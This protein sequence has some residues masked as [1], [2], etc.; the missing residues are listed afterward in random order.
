MRVDPKTDS[1]SGRPEPGW[2]T[3]AAVGQRRW[4]AST[5]TPMISMGFIILA[6]KDGGK[7]F[8]ERFAETEKAIF[9]IA[10]W[11]KATGH[12]EPF[13]TSD[14][15]TLEKIM[16]RGAVQAELVE[17]EYQGKKKIVVGRWRPFS[18]TEDPE[19]QSMISAAESD[20]QK[21]TMELA[22]KYDSRSREGR[23]SSDSGGGGYY[24][25]SGGGDGGNNANDDDIPF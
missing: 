22:E 25:G 9:R 3:A 7:R 13:D 10:N 6:G 23:Q 2:V 21:K 19:W 11:A 17:D 20:F 16:A 12:H 4:Q 5:G 18:G 15:N 1:S 24:G 8:M 14:D